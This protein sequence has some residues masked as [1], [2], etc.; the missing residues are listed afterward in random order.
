MGSGQAKGVAGT[1]E[2]GRANSLQ[3]RREETETQ[4]DGNVRRCLQRHAT[5]HKVRVQG[6]L[7]ACLLIKM[8]D[9]I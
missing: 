1:G 3:H 4:L 8:G 2:K 9:V 5:T 7:K 6:P